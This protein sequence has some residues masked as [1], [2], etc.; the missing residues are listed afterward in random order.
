M[1]DLMTRDEVTGRVRCARSTLYVLMDRDGFPRP[2]KIGRDN[3]WVASEVEAWLEGQ[4]AKRR[5]GG[6]S[7]ATP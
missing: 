4:A 3:R 6:L 2:I 5:V 1:K 7:P